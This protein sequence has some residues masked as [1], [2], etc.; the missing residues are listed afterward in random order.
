M[1]LASAGEAVA[2]EDQAAPCGPETSTVLLN[3]V[4]IPVQVCKD[5]ND[6]FVAYNFMVQ[7]ALSRH[8]R[9][10]Y[11]LQRRSK[12][13]CRTPLALNSMI[14]SSVDLQSKKVDCCRAGCVAFSADRKDLSHCNVCKT[15]RY[16]SNNQPYKQANNW[17]LLPWLKM[18]LADPGIGSGMVK[19]MQ[20]AR[21]AALSGEDGGLGDWYDSSN[22]RKLFE[23][24]YFST[25]TCVAVSISTDGFQAWKQ[26]GFEDW[27]MI[28]TVL[29]V[30]PSSRVQV[31][32]Q[33]VLGITPGP[34]QPADLKSLLHP[35]AEELNALAAGVGGV[36]LAGF[37]EPQVVHVY[38]I[39]F[40]TDMPAGD[41]LLNVVSVNGERPGRFRDFAGVW[42]KRP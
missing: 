20:E 8:A 26:R 3:G 37:Q 21:E 29:N 34:C 2:D 32:S 22:F 42:H 16:R 31:V 24:C 9:E 7:H 11:L 27:P 19:A 13:K 5:N 23:K 18:M 4:C 40:T 17:R 14:E 38:A 25:N 35:V 6:D 30:H 36:T 1:G 12:G 10:D 41:K 33:L 39:N 28:A 15:P